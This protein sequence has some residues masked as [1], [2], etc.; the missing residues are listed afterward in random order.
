MC[1]LRFVDSFAKTS[2][3]KDFSRRGICIFP[4]GKN[5]FGMT[6]A[7]N[8]LNVPICCPSPRRV[9]C[10]GLSVIWLG[11]YCVYRL[12][13]AV[14][15]NGMIPSTPCGMSDSYRSLSHPSRPAKLAP[16]V[17]QPF[18]CH[19]LMTKAMLVRF[20]SLQ[21]YGVGQCLQTVLGK[22]CGQ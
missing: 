20:S 19:S 7:Q 17:C 9:C 2:I 4:E 18:E 10:N 16:T 1:R 11:P 6:L 5:S 3:P 8:P 15:L 21:G 22:P 12:I 13:I 14:F